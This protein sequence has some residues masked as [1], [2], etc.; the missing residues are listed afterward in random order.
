[1]FLF[2]QIFAQVT[3]YKGEWT[4][5]N[6]EDNFSGILKLDIKDTALTGDI[7]WTFV[8][9]DSNDD[10]SVKYYKSQKG[11]TGIEY[12]KGSFFKKNSDI[13][14]EG[15]EKKDPHMIIGLDKYLLKLSLN[16]MVIYGRTLSNGENNGLVYF[17]KI[18]KLIGEKEFNLLRTKLFSSSGEKVMR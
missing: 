8:A 3:Y 9:I 1:M 15:I 6:S 11:K 12:V 2:V 13:Q 18:D 17:Y 4:K 16:K 14:F 7:I 10:A 5:I